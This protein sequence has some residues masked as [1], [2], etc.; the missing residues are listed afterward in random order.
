[1]CELPWK[2][3]GLL[4]DSLEDDQEEVSTREASL[5]DQDPQA[6]PR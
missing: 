1:M 5:D 3:A 4:R 2:M 6:E